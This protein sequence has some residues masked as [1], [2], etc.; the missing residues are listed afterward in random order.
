MGQ[1]YLL[2]ARVGAPRTDDEWRDA[3]ERNVVL[4]RRG[5]AELV[6]DS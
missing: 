1:I 4:L 5:W 3:H 2:I 6:T